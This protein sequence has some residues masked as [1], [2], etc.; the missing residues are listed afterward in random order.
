MTPLTPVID[1]IP[2]IVDIFLNTLTRLISNC[3]AVTRNAKGV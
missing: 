2:D 3:N 1:G